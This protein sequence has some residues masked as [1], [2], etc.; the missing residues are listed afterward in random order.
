MRRGVF[1]Q[2]AEELGVLLAE[3]GVVGSEFGVGGDELADPGVLGCMSGPLV[4]GDVLS[5]GALAVA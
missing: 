2:T 3:P 5:G 4:R 1:A